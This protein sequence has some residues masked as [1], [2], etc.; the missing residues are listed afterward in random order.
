[1]Y[2]IV[3]ACMRVRSRGKTLG[4]YGTTGLSS[5]STSGVQGVEIIL[6]LVS[7]SVLSHIL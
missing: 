6:E 3:C 2:A 7:L 5:H 4:F 1:M